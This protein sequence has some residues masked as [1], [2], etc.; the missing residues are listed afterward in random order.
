MFRDMFKIVL[1]PVYQNKSYSKPE[2]LTDFDLLYNRRKLINKRRHPTEGIY[3]VKE[4]DCRKKFKIKF[5][6][7][8]KEKFV[9]KVNL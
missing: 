9:Q 8:Y 7:N 6:Y 5:K 3:P 2:D 1:D 4:L